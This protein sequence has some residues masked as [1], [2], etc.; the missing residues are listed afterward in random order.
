M[1]QTEV[2]RTGVVYNEL[3]NEHVMWFKGFQNTD[4]HYVRFTFFYHQAYVNERAAEMFIPLNK[5]CKIITF[6]FYALASAYLDEIL[7][8][9]TFFDVEKAV[10]TESLKYIFD[11]RLCIKDEIKK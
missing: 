11:G 8:K 1:H 2:K 5:R 7:E 4:G 9:V 10:K 3:F 6:L